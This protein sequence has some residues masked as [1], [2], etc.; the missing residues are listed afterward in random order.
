MFEQVSVPIWLIVIVSAGWVALVAAAFLFGRA[1]W[2][3]VLDL[4]RDSETAARIAAIKENAI[5]AIHGAA[6]EH[7]I[8][9]AAL[10]GAATGFVAARNPRAIRPVIERVRYINTAVSVE[11]WSVN[12]KPRAVVLDEPP[13][14]DEDR[15]VPTGDDD[16]PHAD[17]AEEPKV[18]RHRVP[19]GLL[20]DDTR[21]IG[22]ASLARALREVGR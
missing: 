6:I 11:P 4:A 10:A 5:R 1:D 16:Y 8:E 21:Q 9:R 15:P 17:V 13:V 18:G 7:V 22:D 2:R 19:D 3:A 20:E 12:I 14:P